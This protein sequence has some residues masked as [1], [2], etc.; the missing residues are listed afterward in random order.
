MQV[1][2]GKNVTGNVYLF[3]IFLEGSVKKKVDVIEA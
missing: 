1:R 2:G 3:Q